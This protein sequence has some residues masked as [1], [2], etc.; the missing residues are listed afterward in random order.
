MQ[1]VLHAAFDTQMGPVIGARAEGPTPHAVNEV[2]SRD[3]HELQAHGG[4]E[5][6]E[7]GADDAAKRLN[8]RIAEHG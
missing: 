5:I 1:R 2:G 6:G 4:I 3:S 7:D 8:I